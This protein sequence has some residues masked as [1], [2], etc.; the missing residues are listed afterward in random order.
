MY[1]IY[2]ACGEPLHKRFPTWSDAY[3]YICLIGRPDWQI[4]KL[5]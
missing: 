1:V 5:Y 3:N 4:K 2:D